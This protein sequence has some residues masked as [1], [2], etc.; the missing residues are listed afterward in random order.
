MLFFKTDMLFIKTDLMINGMWKNMHH[1]WFEKWN[2]L[3]LWIW[4]YVPQW[5][6]SNYQNITIYYL[7]FWNMLIHKL[8]LFVTEIRQKRKIT[9]SNWNCETVFTSWNKDSSRNYPY[10]AT[11]TF[12]ITLIILIITLILLLM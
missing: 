5:Q 1:Y 9:S 2:I 4:I 3:F 10:F 11:I 6:F 8:I 7:I 12:I